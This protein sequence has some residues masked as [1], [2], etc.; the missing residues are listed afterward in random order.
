MLFFFLRSTYFSK[1]GFLVTGSSIVSEEDRRF[2]SNGEGLDGTTLKSGVE[3]EVEKGE[4]AIIL[5]GLSRSMM[6]LEKSKDS[7]DCGG[8]SGKERDARTE[9]SMREVKSVKL[10]SRGLSMSMGKIRSLVHSWLPFETKELSSDCGR[11]CTVVSV[12]T[13]S[14]SI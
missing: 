6:F 2:L 4:E 1:E 14:P 11:G 13:R 3:G 9:E 5:E 12:A 10:S 7:S 8:S